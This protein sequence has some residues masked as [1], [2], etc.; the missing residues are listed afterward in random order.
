MVQREESRRTVMNPQ[1]HEIEETKAFTFCHQKPNPNPNF[2][3]TQGDRTLLRCEHGKRD[4]HQQE[5]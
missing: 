1:S 2:S 3:T 5:E 4:G